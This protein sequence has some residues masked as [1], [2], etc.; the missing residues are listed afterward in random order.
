MCRQANSISLQNYQ[1]FRDNVSN[2]ATNTKL[3]GLPVVSLG[4]MLVKPD[5][6]ASTMD[7][8]VKAIEYE[9]EFTNLEVLTKDQEMQEKRIELTKENHDSIPTVP[10]GTQIVEC[11]QHL[12]SLNL[13]LFFLFRRR[14]AL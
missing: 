13:L 11:N 9:K 2:T 10:T 1:D 7:G 6:L 12:E 4:P 3:G 5:F 8:I 14:N